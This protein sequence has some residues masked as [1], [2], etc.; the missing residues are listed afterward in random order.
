[1]LRLTSRITIG[2][3]TFNNCVEVE[4][5]SGWEDMTDT[6]TITIPRK[7][8]WIDKDLASGST[9][10]LTVGNPVTVELGYDFN[11]STYF[12]GYITNIDAKTPVTIECQDAF[13]FLKQASGS[14]S[15]EKGGTLEDVFDN[16]E[17]VYLASSVF[18]KYNADITFVPLANTVIGKV[19]AN[20][21]SMAFVISSLKKSGIV[22]FM[23]PGNILYSG[24]AYYDNQRNEVLRQFDWNITEDSLEQKN[25]TDTKIKIVVKCVDNPKNLAAVEVGDAEG[26]TVT[27]LVSGVTTQEQMRERGEAELPK[28]KFNGWVGSFTTFGDEYIKHGDVATLTDKVIKDRNGSFFVKKVTTKFGINGFRNIVELHKKL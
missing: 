7:V 27:Y 28:Y 8:K 19:T 18:A 17:R 10:A 9:P 4:V 24:L 1:M 3:Y 5:H 11:Y 6:C 14:F 15:T 2:E 20:N 26:E 25:A 21:V 22:S 16:V 23:R 12:Q 13:W